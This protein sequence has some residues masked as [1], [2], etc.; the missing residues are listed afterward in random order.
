M[1]EETNGKNPK[2]KERFLSS[3]IPLEFV[4]SKKLEDL[5]IG[6]IAE[7]DYLKIDENGRERSFSVDLLSMRRLENG[8]ALDILYECKYKKPNTQWIFIPRRVKDDFLTREIFLPYDSFNER[9]CFDRLALSELTLPIITATKG[10]EIIDNIENAKTIKEGIEQLRYGMLEHYIDVAI[11]HL[12][13]NI[14]SESNSTSL[15]LI[16]GTIVTTA[17]IWIIRENI[18]LEEIYGAKSVSE[19][20]DKVN[21]LYYRDFPSSEFKYYSRKRIS[22]RLREF[23]TFFKDYDEKISSVVE[24]LLSSDNSEDLL[25]I[26]LSTSQ[27]GICHIDYIDEYINSHRK[28]ILDNRKDYLVKILEEES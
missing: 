13:T 20:A 18:G 12:V 3:G 19:V 22:T 23:K 16:M 27:F 25:D 2:W 11:D 4:L 24:E 1:T 17:E 26:S 14:S 5:D 8:V 28:K 15:R 10:T 7:H 9:F 21:Y 6:L